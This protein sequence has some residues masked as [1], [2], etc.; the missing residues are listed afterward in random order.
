[1][2]T[3]TATAKITYS[4]VKVGRGA[5]I[6]YRRDGS[7]FPMCGQTN[8]RSGMTNVYNVV[9]TCKRCIKLMEKR[10]ARLA[11]NA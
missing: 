7:R 4:T 2:S 6:H 5:A 8:L 11:G 9:P 1:M 10:E 3:S